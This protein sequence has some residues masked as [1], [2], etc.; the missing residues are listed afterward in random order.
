MSE[1]IDKIIKIL[2]TAT[3]GMT[4]PMSNLIR[5]NFGPDPYL[6]LISCLLSLRSR[7]PIT[8]K[9]S[10]RLFAHARTPQELLAIPLPELERLLYPLNFYKKKAQVIRSVTRELI[11]RFEGKVPANEQD[12]LSLKGVGPKTA[13]LV[14]GI[15]FDIPAICV[16]THVHRLSN[17]LGLVSTKTA[18]KTEQALKNIVPRNYWIS[19]NKLF[20]MWGQNVCLP[21]LPW[22]SRCKLAPLCPRIGVKSSR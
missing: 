18:E 16:D 3:K 17:R 1:R 13:A 10:H 9:V 11:E 7:D 22:C 21:V 14:L 6:I 8:Y 19:I 5:N 15:A 4:L 12:L 20:V 2:R